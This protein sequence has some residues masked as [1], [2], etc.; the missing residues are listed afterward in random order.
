MTAAQNPP[1]DHV[2]LRR[3]H[4]RGH[5]DAETIHGILDAMPLCHVGY[6]IDGRPAVTPTLQWREGNT[7][8]WHGSSASRMRDARSTSPLGLV[9]SRKKIQSSEN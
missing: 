1:T 7:V 5:Y 6:V 8:Y 9:R 4:Q 2:R 3:L